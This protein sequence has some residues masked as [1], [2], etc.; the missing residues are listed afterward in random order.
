M[1]SRKKW[2]A[3]ET[4]FTLVE[5]TVGFV[6]I[7]IIALSILMLYAAMVSSEI[8][9]KRKAVASTLATN[10]M[11]YLKS[12]PYNNLAVVGGSIVTSNP[13]PASSITTING[14]KYNTVTSIN[15]VDDAF[16]GCGNYPSQP[17]KLTYCRN[18]PP[19]TGAQAVDTNRADYKIIHVSVFGPT[20]VKFAEVDTQVSAR[21]AETA[22]STGALFVSVI[23]ST[24]NPVGGATI[25]VTNN[26]LS[27]TV[28]VS[29]STDSNGNAVF[30]DLPPDTTGY[31][32]VI[33]ASLSNYSSVTTIA[34]SGSLQPN[35]S[36]QRIFTQ[37]SSLVTLT[38]KPKGND[39]LVIETTNVS[40]VA[41]GN[42]KVN[43]KGGYKKYSNTTD[44]SYYYDTLSPSDIRPTTNGS[45][46]VGVHN[47]VPG[48]YIFCGDTGSTGCVVGGTTYYLAAAVPYNSASSFNPIIVPSFTASAPPAI[49]YAFDDASYLQKVRLLLTTNSNFPR[50]QSISPSDVSISGGTLSSFGFQI[51]G[52]NLPCSAVA[53]SCQTSV[54]FTKDSN[55]YTASCTGNASGLTLNCTV[56]MSG[57]SVGIAQLVITSNGNTLTLPGSPLLGGINV[58]P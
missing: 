51:G 16:D 37:L 46:L 40:G 34:P 56:N 21:V 30:Y 8:L 7:G 52:V 22:S 54:R 41:L 12:L 19:P 10:Q 9:N 28:S 23:D 1:Y 27:P 20:G 57:A 31:D 3:N 42:V 2:G 50:V 58:T 53:A 48:S 14:Y 43:F 5:L 26:T 38:L 44:T 6:V 11:E 33:T 36:S 49:T 45:G 25:S 29:D 4:G 39:S 24:G 55:T 47:L 18:Y 15:Y 13:L 32:Y 17:L 35:Y